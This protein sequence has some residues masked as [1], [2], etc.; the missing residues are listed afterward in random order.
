MAL[1]VWPGARGRVPVWPV[2][3]EGRGVVGVGGGSGRQNRT[4]A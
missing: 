1:G 2:P 3:A 4:E